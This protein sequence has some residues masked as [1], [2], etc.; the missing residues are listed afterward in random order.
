METAICV[1]CNKSATQG[2]ICHKCERRIL[3][4][5]DDLMEFWKAAHEEL[6]PGRS[7]NGGSSSERTI[8]VNVAALSFVAG[9]DILGMLHEWEKL[10]REDRKLTPPALIVKKSTLAEE[11]KDAVDF[12]KLHLPWSGTQPWIDDFAKELKELHKTGMSAAKAWVSKAKMIPC[13]AEL[14]DGQCNQ[15]L[16]INADDPLA[17][18][19]CRKC[20]TQW[21]TL[22]LVAVA[23]SDR[24][25]EIWVDSEAIA[26]WVGMSQRNVQR[27]VKDQKI[28]RRGELINLN[29]FLA[30]NAQK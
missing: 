7:G 12:A 20:D 19:G 6:L 9:D 10:I 1:L 3:M 15:V 13:P 30:F 16:K 18:F 23:L 5:L 4:Q 27:I 29:A 2:G 11:I 22:R 14:A 8:G 21:T 24:T 25:R 28:A 17:I 26:N